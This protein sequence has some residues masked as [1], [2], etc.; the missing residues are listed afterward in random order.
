MTGLMIEGARLSRPAISGTQL[1]L[2]IEATQEGA[3][4][5]CVCRRIAP[6]RKELPLPLIR[7]LFLDGY[8]KAALVAFL[9]ALSDEDCEY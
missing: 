6:A 9:R 8:E 7:P 3:P 2:R 5:I 1:A 4:A